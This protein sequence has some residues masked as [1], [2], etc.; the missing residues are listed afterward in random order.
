MCFVT[1]TGLAA[2]M[3]VAGAAAKGVGSIAQGYAAARN[4]REAQKM[5][6]YQSQVARA[7]AEIAEQNAVRA[8]QSAGV[9]AENKSREVGARVGRLRAAQAAAG[10]DVN[11]GTAVDVQASTRMLG[12][13]DTET[14][15]RNELLKAY[16]YRNDARNFENDAALGVY[17]SNVTGARAGDAITS[18]Y[19]KAG[20]DLMSSLSSLPTK[21]GG[22][23][24]G[25]GNTGPTGKTYAEELAAG[26]RPL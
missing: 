14:V 3:A 16:G 23:T 7:N 21:W 17:R 8:E 10:V 2:G 12:K 1:M 20:G 26:E 4:A 25:A 24:T 18:G 9:A 6:Y 11:T 13:A 19:L 15:F 5:G 22:E